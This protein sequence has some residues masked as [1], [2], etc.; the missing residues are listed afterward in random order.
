MQPQ[1]CATDASTDLLGLAR[2]HLTGLPNRTQQWL[3]ASDRRQIDCPKALSGQHRLWHIL[4]RAIV[5]AAALQIE[6]LVIVKR[7]GVEAA[8]TIHTIGVRLQDVPAVEEGEVGVNGAH[9]LFGK[10]MA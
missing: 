2:R 9:D 3:Q 6:G 1:G 5:Q 8:R 4:T 7:I 10:E